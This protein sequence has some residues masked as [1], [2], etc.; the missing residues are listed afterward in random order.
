MIR[1]PPKSILFPYTT[2]FRSQDDWGGSA[3]LYKGTDRLGWWIKAGQHQEKSK[4]GGR[5][6]VRDDSDL[7]GFR[8]RYAKAHGTGSRRIDKLSKELAGPLFVGCD[9]GSTT[10]KAVVLSSMKEL[11]Y[12]AYVQSNG[13]PIQDAQALFR[14]IRGGGVSQIAA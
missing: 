14:D 9:F 4:P 3:A 5:G 6:L 12:T 8:S 2:F 1:R 7:S 10:A 11:L 13:N